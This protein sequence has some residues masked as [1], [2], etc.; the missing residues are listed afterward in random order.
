MSKPR[1]NS[2]REQLGSLEFL[3][4]LAILRRNGKA[5]GLGIVSAI[6]EAGLPVKPGAVYTTLSRLEKKKMVQSKVGKSTNSRGGR[7][8]RYFALSAHGKVV[9]RRSFLGIVQLGEGSF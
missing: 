2:R 5:F 3:V 4:L 1:K 8:K 6:E 7:A 9:A